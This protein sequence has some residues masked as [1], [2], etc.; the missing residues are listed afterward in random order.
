VTL[1]VAH[2]SAVGAVMAADSHVAEEDHTGGL[3]DKIWTTG[4]LLFGY[5]GNMAVRDRLRQAIEAELARSPLPVPIDCEMAASQLKASMRPILQQAYADFVGGPDDSPVEAL[6]GSLLVVGRD[7]G[8]YWL[9]EIDRNNTSSHYTEDGFHTTGSGSTAAHVGRRLL[10][11]YALP[12]YETKHLRLLAMRTVKSCIDVLGGAYGLGGPVQLW[13]AT[14]NGYEQVRGDEL[15]S[16]VE[17]VQQ[18]VQIEKE[19]LSKVFA[20]TVEAP[21]GPLPD[22]LQG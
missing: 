10:Q 21:P 11:H 18:W 12:G 4:T 8:R 1:I 22:A 2:V 17:G 7:N 19:S 5:S 13:Q 14:D 15:A 16:V 9:L 6:G 20:A 3:A